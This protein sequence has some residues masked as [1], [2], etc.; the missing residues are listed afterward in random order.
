MKIKRVIK[1]VYYA[2][3][4]KFGYDPKLPY[5]MDEIYDNVVKHV[6]LEYDCK[7]ILLSGAFAYN[8]INSYISDIRDYVI[9][10]NNCTKKEYVGKFKCGIK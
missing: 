9:D 7:H 6:E 5:T 4:L 2:D 10:W 3:P 1:A 8:Q